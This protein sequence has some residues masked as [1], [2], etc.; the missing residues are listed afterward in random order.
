MACAAAWCASPARM[1]SLTTH[2]TW[3][4]AL[5]VSEANSFP[6][7]SLSLAATAETAL[8]PIALT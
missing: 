5:S 8:P 3:L 6:V 7:T 4:R 2:S 1:S